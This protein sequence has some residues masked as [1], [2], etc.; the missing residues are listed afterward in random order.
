M[1][2]TIL[3]S[4]MVLFLFNLTA[5]AKYAAPSPTPE[6]AAVTVALAAS[7]PSPV[8]VEDRVDDT[9][10]AILLDVSENY[11]PATAGCSLRAARLAGTLLDW[12]AA[13]A[14]VDPTAAATMQAFYA[15]LSKEDASFF[16]EEQLP[17]VYQGAL[18]LLSENGSDLLE[19]AGYAPSAYP[20]EPA[21]AKALFTALFS[22]MDAQLPAL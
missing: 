10:T 9:L 11:H 13:S 14:P 12:A 16:A 19:S 22:G 5:C 7:T 21:L 2:K 1:K 18:A 20:W 15:K 4:L 17:A 6:A 8:Q 3:W